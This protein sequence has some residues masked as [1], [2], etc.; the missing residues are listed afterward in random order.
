MSTLDC[1]SYIGC[2]KKSCSDRCSSTC[3]GPV[4]DLYLCCA[5]EDTRHLRKFSLESSRARKS[6]QAM[7]QI[8][9][10]PSSSSIWVKGFQRTIISTGGGSINC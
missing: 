10:V 4:L 3:I 1:K 9:E 6:S 5:A 2:G 7:M 8:E